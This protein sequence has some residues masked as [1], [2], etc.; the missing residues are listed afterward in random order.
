LLKQLRSSIAPSPSDRTECDSPIASLS[1]LQALVLLLSS[2]HFRV[3]ACGHGSIQVPTV[4]SRKLE[5]DIPFYSL[6]LASTIPLHHISHFPLREQPAP[7]RS[8]TGAELSAEVPMCKM[9]NTM[10][11]APSPLLRLAPEVRQCI[12]RELL[13]QSVPLR[14]ADPEKLDPY[15]ACE[16]NSA[17][18]LQSS[19]HAICYRPKGRA[20]SMIIY[21]PATSVS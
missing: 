1:E 14:K 16:Q 6:P 10:E 17:S 15:S 7:K 12:L 9:S 4:S 2:Y 18:A 13:W 20:F 19:E 5:Q 21:L 11:A 3:P 8:R